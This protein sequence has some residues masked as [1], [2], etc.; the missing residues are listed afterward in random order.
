MTE[1]ETEAI[2]F[3]HHHLYKYVM[4]FELEI[5]CDTNFNFDIIYFDII[6]TFLFYQFYPLVRKIGRSLKCP[7]LGSYN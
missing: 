2:L 3:L 4:E 6:F 1:A 7:C 5:F